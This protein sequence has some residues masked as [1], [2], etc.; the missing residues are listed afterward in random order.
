MPARSA[1]RRW[2]SCSAWRRTVSLA[3]ASRSRSTSRS[4]WSG[5]PTLYY[6]LSA[7]DEEFAELFKIA[8]DF[9]DR[10]E[11]TAETTLL[12]ARLIARSCGA[13]ICGRFDRDAVA[14]VIEQARPPRRRCRPAVDQHA[15]ASSI[16]CRRPISSPPMPAR[17]SSA[18]PK[19]RPR[20]T[21]R[22]AAAT[23]SIAGCRRR[24]RRST[25]R[26]ETDG[27]QIGQINGLV[28][29]HASARSAFGN[30]SRITAQ[31]RLGRGEVVDIE[32]EVAARRA[33]AFEG[34]A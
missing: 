8:A 32:R 25:I 20:S 30:P 19:C 33:A 7:Q 9:E 16:C 18:R 2:S 10:V 11:R 4:C 12:Y 17:R 29:D 34:R 3:A 26:I 31:V 21:P 14:R 24:S 15:R 28:G 1:S 13:R 23:A 6:L 5:P 27:E 22:S